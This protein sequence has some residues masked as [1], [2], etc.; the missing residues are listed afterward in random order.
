MFPSSLKDFACAV[1]F[2]WNILFPQL[3]A[4]LLPHILKPLLEYHLLGAPHLTTAQHFLTP[5]PA[6]FFFITLLTY[7]IFICCLSPSTRSQRPFHFC[8]PNISNS[9]YS[10]FNNY[11]VNTCFIEVFMLTESINSNLA[12]K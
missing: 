2:T 11:S 7:H 3:H 10:T 8:I 5:Y 6:L 9:H 4:L 1:P 12:D